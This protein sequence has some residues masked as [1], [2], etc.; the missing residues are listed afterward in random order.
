MNWT[1]LDWKN[2]L[3]RLR[4]GFPAAPPPRA[5]L[6]KSRDDLAHYDATYAERIGWKW[7][8]GAARAEAPGLGTAR[9]ERARLGL[10]QRHRRP[11]HDRGVWPRGVRRAARVGPLAARDGVRQRSGREQFPALR[12]GSATASFLGSDEPIGLLVISHVLTE[13]PA[14]ALASCAG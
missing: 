12:V 7:D 2:S 13:L 1:A 8:A 5:L 14:A 3:D 4:E 10:R 6:L 9:A 11:A